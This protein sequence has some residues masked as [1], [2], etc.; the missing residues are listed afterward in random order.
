MNHKQINQITNK[1]SLSLYDTLFEEFEFMKKRLNSNMILSG[2]FFHDVMV[3]LTSY[4][5]KITEIKYNLVMPNL[6]KKRLRS[7]PYIDYDDIINDR[8]Y[9]DKQ[10]IQNINPSL[11]YRYKLIE[12]VTSLLNINGKKIGFGMIP[13]E[14]NLKELVIELIR[15]Q[16]E[17]IFFLNKHYKVE[18][19]KYEYQLKSLIDRIYHFIP[20]PM[21]KK[22]FISLMKNYFSK[23]NISNTELP[24]V[25]VFIT[26]EILAGK[27][28]N[29]LYA[30]SYYEKGSK[31]IGVMHG[32]GSGILNEPNN[33][34]GEYSFIS[35]LVLY[36]QCE[37]NY[38]IEKY[39]KP[40]T[41]VQNYHYFSDSTVKDIYDPKVEIKKFSDFTD[42][43]ILYVPTLFC[44]F[45]TYGPF[46]QIPDKLYINWM[47]N[48]SKSIPNIF[49]KTH[50]KG[51]KG[52]ENDIN[53]K[54]IG[55]YF[56]EIMNETDVFI[57]DYIGSAFTLACATDKPVIF[58]N[59]GINN[60]GNECYKRIKER[61]IFIEINDIN[62]SSI[63]D[64]MLVQKNKRLINNYTTKYSL[65]ADWHR[66]DESLNSILYGIINK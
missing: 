1:F 18:I 24:D 21:E 3:L 29:R 37:L 47:G 27:S 57:F 8:N 16:N 34:Y 51:F 9:S 40:L 11:D 14:I 38:N 25:D 44:G 60:I 2:L 30:A 15:N 58:F 36:G 56:E 39:Q 32:Y 41:N 59:L 55:G 4:F 43:K 45:G 65:S 66:E 50:P 26:G 12:K 63:Y 42:P 22:Y 52:F 46:R 19:P 53:V 20:R 23:Q 35:D 62:D 17:V 49:F 10:I 61:T 28:M 13:Q 54:Y 6:V 64:K 31:V 7:F 5:I 33:G 48:I